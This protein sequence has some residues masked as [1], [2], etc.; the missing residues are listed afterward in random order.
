MSC[1]RL[2]LTSNRAY[3]LLWVVVSFW[4]ILPAQLALVSFLFVT[5]I[6]IGGGVSSPVRFFSSNY[7]SAPN[8]PRPV[9]LKFHGPTAVQRVGRKSV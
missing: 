2:L 7:R 3:E 6:C 1:F 5:R 4:K 9:F 8:G